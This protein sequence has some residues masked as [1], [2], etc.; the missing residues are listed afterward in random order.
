[1]FTK[2]AGFCLAIAI[3]YC[4]A[5][6]GAAEPAETITYIARPGD[7]L[8]GIAA[9][10]YKLNKPGLMSEDDYAL[11]V[12]VTNNKLHNLDRKLQIGDEVKVPVFK[13]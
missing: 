5:G 8:N 9:Q 10:H 6:W 13:K 3:G 7:T 1:M 12:R 2:I 4:A 11:Q